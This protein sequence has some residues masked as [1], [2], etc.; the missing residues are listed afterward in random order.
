M[1]GEEF[2]KKLVKEIKFVEWFFN[3]KFFIIENNFYFNESKGFLCF[4]GKILNSGSVS[5]VYCMGEIKGWKYFVVY[6]EVL[7]CLYEYFYLFNEKFY[8]MV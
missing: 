4:V 6:R 5:R 3:L 2:I 1:S 7:K 8:F